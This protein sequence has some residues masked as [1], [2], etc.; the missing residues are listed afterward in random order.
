MPVPDPA[1][2][3]DRERRSQ[4]NHRAR[5]GVPVAPEELP[6][7]HEHDRAGRETKLDVAIWKSAFMIS[8]RMRRRS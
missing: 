3:A 5:T 4:V 6:E 7:A 2:D 8:A 1:L